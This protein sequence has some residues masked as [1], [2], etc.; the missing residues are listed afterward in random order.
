MNEFIITGIGGQG[1]ITCSKLILEAALERGYEVRST[2]TIG[3]AQ[4]GG[5]VS[6]HVKI[7]KYIYSP[8]IPIGRA[9]KIIAMEWI[10]GI[11]YQ[12]YLTKGGII[13]VVTDKN[14]RDCNLSIRKDISVRSYELEGCWEK[15]GTKKNMNILMLG[16]AFSN[17]E[18]IISVKDIEKIIYR[19]YMGEIRN[20]NL[21]ALNMGRE[22]AK[23]RKDF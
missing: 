15:L 18:Y 20:K 14:L 22:L 17:E 11:R 8:V 23:I 3:M 13:E 4:R 1:V 2:E 5:S 19:K 16:I 10:E 7:G 12:D 9:N 21:E 6:S